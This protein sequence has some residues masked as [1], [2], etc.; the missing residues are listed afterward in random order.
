MSMHN[1]V[2]LP[3][4][5]ASNRHADSGFS[6]LEI[7][8]LV[9]VR[10]IDGGKTLGEAMYR[11]FYHC[12]RNWRNGI[13]A[14]V[15]IVPAKDKAAYDAIANENYKAA[16]SGNPR[17]GE[18]DTSRDWSDVSQFPWVHREPGYVPVTPWTPTAD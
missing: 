9:R 3:A 14:D 7:E 8:S 11:A 1:I 15:R 16:W 2:D 4:E 18:R 13:D 6:V 10:L 5:E 17:N 12:A